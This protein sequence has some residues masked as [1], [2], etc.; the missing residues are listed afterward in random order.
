MTCNTFDSNTEYATSDDI[1]DENAVLSDDEHPVNDYDE[2]DSE[3]LSEYDDE[4]SVNDNNDEYDSEDV[5]EYDDNEDICSTDDCMEDDPYQFHIKDYLPINEN[6]ECSVIDVLLMIEAL[7]IRHNLNWTTVADINLLINSILKIQTLPTTTHS[8]KKKFLSKNYIKQTFHFC[9]EKCGV[10][11]GTKQE[12]QQ[13]DSRTCTN[14][15]SELTTQTKYKNN[16]FIS[17]PLKPQIKKIIEDNP[18]DISLNNLESFN[19][20]KDIFD[21]DTYQALKGDLKDSLFITLTTNTD[22]GQIFKKTKDGSLWPLQHFINE[23]KM[24]KRFSR[25]KILCSGFAFGKTPDMFCFFKPFLE[26]INNINKEGGISIILNHK[27]EKVF[28]IPLLFTFDSVAK[29]HVLNKVQYNGHFGCPICEHPGVSIDSVVRYCSVAN[30]DIRENHTVW[31]NMKDAHQ[32]RVNVN[33]YKGLSPL[34]AIEANIFNFVWQVVIDKMHA[35]DL[36]V[37]KKLLDLWLHPKNS[38]KRLF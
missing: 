18:H 22:G 38:T 24:S 35:I 8:Y 7:R 36:G 29:C 21:G 37:M 3:N 11:V 30:V 20:I 17:I 5:P 13:S 6:V 4:H 9:C 27:V 14:C 12:L 26:E 16:F 34:M 33:G 1:S 32:T 19:N 23:F 25:E 10:Y 2:H 15:F 31:E 28:V